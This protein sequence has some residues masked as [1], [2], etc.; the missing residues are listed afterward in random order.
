MAGMD[1]YFSVACCSKRRGVI[2]GVLICPRCDFA[3]GSATGIPNENLV[4]D[5]PADQ[6]YIY[7][8]KE[9]RNQA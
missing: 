3:H 2:A 1:G 7:I 8:D 6:W 5:M 9:G 4:R